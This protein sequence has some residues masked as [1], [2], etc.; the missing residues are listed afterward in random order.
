MLGAFL[1]LVWV[2]CYGAPPLTDDF[3]AYNDG[4][5][6]GQGDWAGLNNKWWIEGDDVFEGAKALE[7]KGGGGA[8]IYKI[9][10][11]QTDGQITFYIKQYHT[12]QNYAGMQFVL[13]D[14]SYNQIIIGIDY[15]LESKIYYQTNAPPYFNPIGDTIYN[16]WFYIQLKWQADGHFQ[17]NLN[18]EGWSEWLDVQFPVQWVNVDRVKL[19]TS[20]NSNASNYPVVDYIAEE[21]Q[22][23][24]SAVVIGVDPV[25]G[26]AIT[27][28]TD[29]LEINWN[30]FDL[31]TYAGFNY[32]FIN[33]TTGISSM[34]FTQV[35]SETSGEI[36]KLFSD[37]QIDTNGRWDLKAYAYG[38]TSGSG[39]F[40]RINLTSPN[41]VDPEYYVDFDVLGYSEPLVF[42]DFDDWYLEN[43]SPTYTT[44]SVWASSMVDYIEPLFEKINEYSNKVYAYMN[45]DDAYT[46]G[47]AI[48]SV[49]PVV[50]AYITKI[51]IFFGGFPLS[52][53]F[54]WCIVIM[55]SLFVVKVILKLLSFIPFL[56]IG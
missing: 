20:S 8:G 53:F 34:S 28:D 30:Y 36:F 19:L 7:Y 11:A 32:A 52:A 21:T 33:A 42:Q 44:P 39:T 23:P 27:D 35:V 14:A 5:L 46:K 45:L 47:L 18:G 10:T 22:T 55:V 15:D 38:H 40:G 3:N 50:D 16:E 1:L 12:D 13:A 17:Y 6:V 56:N 48:G 37:F 54:K 24:P 41:L 4:E 9:G 51:D 26:S 31:E 49:F 43:V 2:V 29:T 25:S